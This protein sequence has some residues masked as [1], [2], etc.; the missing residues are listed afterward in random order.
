M[1]TEK[2]AGEELSLRRKQ[3]RYRAW[4]RGTREM[5]LVLG[6]FADAHLDAMAEKELERLEALM[7]EEDTDLLSWVVGQTEPPADVDRDLLDRV[8]AFRATTSPAR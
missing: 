1:A 4:H 3:L 8:V 6:P 7:A 5:D 2:S